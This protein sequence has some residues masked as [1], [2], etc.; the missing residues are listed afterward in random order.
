MAV[1]GAR[2]FGVVVACVLLSVAS[3]VALSVVQQA[4]HRCAAAQP[5]PDRDR[6]RSEGENKRE[7]E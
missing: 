3:L 1:G 2:L 6:G 4:G 5:T 7:N